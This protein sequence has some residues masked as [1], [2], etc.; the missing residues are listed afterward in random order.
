M[1]CYTAWTL[2]G[3]SSLGKK[4][5]LAGQNRSNCREHFAFSTDFAFSTAINNDVRF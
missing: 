1:L 2:Q 3:N 4:K 5:G